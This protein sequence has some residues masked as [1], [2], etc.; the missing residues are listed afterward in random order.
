MVCHPLQHNSAFLGYSAVVIENEYAYDF[1]YTR[2][3]V[4]V[5]YYFLAWPINSVVFYFSVRVDHIRLSFVRK[6][7]TA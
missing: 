2:D 7:I 6:N 4:P 1:T 3:I 5:F